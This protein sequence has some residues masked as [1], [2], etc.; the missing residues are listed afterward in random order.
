MGDGNLNLVFLIQGARSALVVKQALPY[1]RMVGTSWPLALSR[2][3]FEN[4]AL[5][6]QARWAASFVPTVHAADDD[7]A[8]TVMQYLEPHVVLRKGLLRGLRYHRVGEH[9]GRFLASTLYH[10]SDLHLSAAG[11]KARVADFLGNTAMCKISEDLIFDEPYFAASMNRHTAPYLDPVSIALRADVGLKLEVQE[12]KWCFQNRPEALIHG[13]LHLGSVMVTETDTRV[14]DPEFA[15][16]GPLSFD[17]GILLG[18]FFMTYFAQAGVPSTEGGSGHD[19][20]LVA[21]AHAVWRTFVHEFAALWRAERRAGVGGALFAARLYVD[22]PALLD[23]AIERRLAVIWTQ[24]L[25]F[26][27]C[28]MIR[29]I[30]G[31]AHVEDFEAI[32]NVAV[33]AACERCAVDFARELLLHRSRYSSMEIVLDDLAAAR[34]P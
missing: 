19:G 31:L 12:L 11:K 30:V 16:Y 1:V 24:A 2:A 18:N 21:Q 25:G 32:A 9:L 4:L 22:A 23:A 7:M 33:R 14:I 13:D 26:A 10:T 34:T 17:V 15:F 6:E 27:G 8:L 3:H 20:Y 29:R 5:I 28:E